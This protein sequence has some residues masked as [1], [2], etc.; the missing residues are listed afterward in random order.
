MADAA[1]IAPAQPGAPGGHVTASGAVDWTKVFLGFGGMVI[2]QFMAVLDVQIVAS[3][4]AQIQA[5]VGASADQI[6]WVQTIYLLA[7]VVMIPLAA[8][9]SKMWGTRPFFMA[10][11][12]VFIAASILTGM[13]TS[14]EMMIVTRAIQGL[15]GGAMIPQVFAAAMTVFPLE[16][17][18]TANVVVGLIVTLAPTIGPTVGGHLT[19][20][21]GWRW[22]FYINVIPGLLSLFLVARY[23]DFDKGDPS[24]AKGIDWTG[25]AFM[26][27]FLLSMQY[28]LEEGSGEGWLK[29]DAILWLS[30]LAALAG[31][32]FVWRQLTYRQ[33]IVSL[34]PFSDRNFVIGTVMNFVSGMSLYSGT[35]VLPLYLAQVRD[36]SPGQVGTTMLVSGLAMF[37]AAPIAGRVIRAMDL[38]IGM[39]L[40]FSLVGIGLGQGIH[41]GDDW[42]FNE[43]LVLQVCRGLGAMIAMIAASQ[44]SIST[45]PLSMM[46]DGSGLLNLIRNV[47][48][49]VGLAMVTTI[50]SRM[51]VVHMGTLSASLNSGSLEAQEMM[52][53]LAAMMEAAGAL[54]PQGGMYKMMGMM[55]QRKALVMAFADV[56]MFLTVG[57]AAAVVLALLARPAPAAPAQPP[58]S[59]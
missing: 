14:F 33:P 6:S 34:A 7:E 18:I 5:G 58:G 36:Y 54:D 19:D 50:L 2:G 27:V 40:G 52:T 44:M 20:A 31:A 32:A 1:V 13:A 28:V 38:R 10:A 30:V 9:F 59:R 25:L 29:D 56:F 37:L 21:F 11:T 24:L 26:A 39:V 22:L 48:G 42:G 23:A 41:V 57:C 47:G 55:L 12:V 51:S 17:R 4:L 49:A 3:S 45:L 8:Y 16:R 35:F 43:F 46:K 53:R 15:A